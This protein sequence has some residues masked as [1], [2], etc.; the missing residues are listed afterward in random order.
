MKINVIDGHARHINPSFNPIFGIK[1]PMANK[2]F[3]ST[4]HLDTLDRKD[5]LL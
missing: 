3:L 1:T 4:S 2:H 5:D